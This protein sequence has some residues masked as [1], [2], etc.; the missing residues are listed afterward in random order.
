MKWQA[1]IMS[2]K[3]SEVPVKSEV[4]PSEV[5]TLPFITDIP[6]N[7][8]AL[9]IRATILNDDSTT[10]LATAKLNFSQVREGFLKGDEWAD[11][12]TF[13]KLT[14]EALKELESK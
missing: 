3:V 8:I 11:D 9:E 6:E 5:K 7:T 12:N 1:R 14:D 10:Q 13:Y 2:K 4:K